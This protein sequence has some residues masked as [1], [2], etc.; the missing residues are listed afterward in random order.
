MTNVKCGPCTWD[1]V[2][3][4]S[5]YYQSKV[6]RANIPILKSSSHPSRHQENA[7]VDSKKEI[8]LTLNTQIIAAGLRMERNGMAGRR[9]LVLRSRQSNQ[10]CA[11][12]LS[13]RM[14]RSVCSVLYSSH[15]P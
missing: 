3:I 8:L 9:Q 10:C 2:A 15:E 1:K 14:E 11:V 12:E 4:V 7:L 13:V 6:F 5:H